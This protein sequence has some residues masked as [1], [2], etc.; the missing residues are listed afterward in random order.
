MHT[1]LKVSVHTII[2][3][4]GIEDIMNIITTANSIEKI[5]DIADKL[6]SSSMVF[7]LYEP[8]E[9]IRL[10]DMAMI[11]DSNAKI[12][13]LSV[14]SRDDKL[15]CIGGIKVRMNCEI[16]DD[17]LNGS[18]DFLDKINSVFTG[19]YSSN[20]GEKRQFQSVMQSTATVNQAKRAAEQQM[21]VA[22]NN[23]LYTKNGNGLDARQQALFDIIQLS[24]EDTDNQEI[25]TAGF[26]DAIA[27][28]I[29]DTPD[30]AEME[31]KVHEMKYGGIIWDHMKNHI[32]DL[33]RIVG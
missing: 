2:I 26:M 12:T 25:G 5:R 3:K 6:D 33:R 27:R 32:P 11:H 21:K 4:K 17:E 30:V 24:A 22:N 8:E 10:D 15:L 28:I 29:R 1:N 9:T 31:R 23:A 16:L 14:A 19:T 20:P 18:L 7:I 13:F